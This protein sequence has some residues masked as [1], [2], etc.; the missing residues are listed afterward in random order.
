M[1]FTPEQLVERRVAEIKRLAPIEPSPAYI[2]GALE[3]TLEKVIR[4]CPQARLMIE[5]SIAYAETLPTPTR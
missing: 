4:E 2:Q 5:K 1:D 3:A